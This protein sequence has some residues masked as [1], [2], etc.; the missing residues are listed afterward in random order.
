MGQLKNIYRLLWFRQLLYLLPFCFPPAFAQTPV[1][2]NYTVSDGLPSQTV[3]SVMQDKKGY[4]W[5]T[6]DAGV[7]RF[8]GLHFKNFTTNDGLTDNEVFHIFEDSK[9]RLWFTTFNGKP[10]YYLDGKFYSPGNDSVLARIRNT[11]HLHSFYEDSSHTIWLGTKNTTAVIYVKENG[12]VGNFNLPDSLTVAHAVYIYKPDENHMWFDIFG[13]FYSYEQGK[14]TPLNLPNTQ[15]MAQGVSM[16]HLGPGKAIYIS[17]R[18]IELLEGY[19]NTLLTENSDLYSSRGVELFYDKI[20]D[21]IW[22]T[23]FGIGAMQYEKGPDGKFKLKRTLLEDKIII[24]GCCDREGN[25][26][27]ASAG[28]GLFMISE[29]NMNLQSYTQHDG[30]EPGPVVCV[31][32]DSQK[33]KWLASNNCK[34]ICLKPDGEIY[35]IDCNI[36]GGAPTRA[37]GI[38]T[39]RQNNILVGTDNGVVFIKS[40]PGN[41]FAKPEMILTDEND[42]LPFKSFATSKNGDVYV[43]HSHGIAKIIKDN[44]KTGYTVKY[45]RERFPMLRT[46]TLFFDHDDSLW[47]SNI[48]GLCI[49]RKDTLHSLGINMPELSSRIFSIGE[50]EDSTLVLATY[51][52]GVLFYKN[53]NIIN[54]LREADGLAGSICKKVI[55]R[56]DT[57]YIACIGGLTRFVYRN[58]TISSLTNFTVSDG[59]LSNAVN[60]AAVQDGVMYIATSLGMSVVPSR[61]RG[62]SAGP[63]AVYITSVKRNGE[64]AD[65]TE[66]IRLDY[67]RSFLQFNFIAPVFDRPENVVYSY[68]LAEDGSGWMETR[69]NNVEFISLV[70]GNYQFLVRARKGNSSWSK[71][72]SMMFVIDPPFWKTNWFRVTVCLLLV[73]MI[74]LLISRRI[75]SVRKKASEKALLDRKIAGLE[76]KALRAQMNPH[77]TFNVMN[78]IQN[79]IVNHDT[80]SALRYLSKFARLIRQILENS[81]YPVI[82]LSDEISALEIYMELEKLRFKE[83]FSYEIRADEGIDLH[84]VFVPSMLLQPYVENAIKHGILHKKE[85]GKVAIIITRDGGSIRCI[86]EDNGI[87]RAG[88][89]LLADHAGQKHISLGTQITNQRVEAF[90]V[91][92][93]SNISLEITDLVNDTQ[94]GNGTRVAIN[95]PPENPKTI[96]YD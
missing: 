41:K 32:I 27:L 94:E 92:Y 62:F 93:N 77:F 55:I 44:N 6:T 51:G 12:E 13:R 34:V 84:S 5:V 30:L 50:S 90:N 4:I 15:V 67:D 58:N 9:G 49:N 91:S 1:Y 37:L 25:T 28:Y 19:R 89:A 43:S 18:G 38:A 70:P 36:W 71:P 11:G 20:R 74:Y 95:I 31:K 61:F 76:M 24:S 68:Q 60:D 66:E 88:A 21:H 46:Y 83:K 81:Q 3:Y 86:I 33:N 53:G 45:L 7:S 52:F 72:A 42:T 35:K 40:M 54:R 17:K 65:T 10:C 63:P 82:R 29:V 96:S 78:S 39:D 22:V 80:T 23:C 73:L 69:N 16:L 26:W 75:A 2:K 47:I 79:Y 14:Y 57:V 85:G 48:T 87:G 56:G 59:L 64:P 8:D